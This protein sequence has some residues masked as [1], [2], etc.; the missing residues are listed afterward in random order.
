MNDNTGGIDREL[1]WFGQNFFSVAKTL[2]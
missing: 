2:N 1:R